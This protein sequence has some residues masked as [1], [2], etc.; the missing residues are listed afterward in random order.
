MLLN[1]RQFKKILAAGDTDKVS[2]SKSS[3]ADKEVKDK[4]TETPASNKTLVQEDASPVSAPAAPS[5][6][7]SVSDRFHHKSNYPGD[8]EDNTPLLD[9][10]FTTLPFINS[11]QLFAAFNDSISS[12][13]HTIHPWQLDMSNELCQPSKQP[14]S[15]HPLKY[16]LVAANGS[17]KDSFIIAPFAVW[18]ILTKI[19]SRV[20]I[21]SSSGTQLTSQ[22]ETYIKALAERINER[23]GIEIFR[24]RQRYIKCRKTGSEIRMFA[25]D[26]AG[27][28]EG[29]HP[30]DPGAEMCIIINEGKSIAPEIYQ[31][32]RRC[33][34]Y[35]Y[36]IEVSSPGEPNGD[37]YESYKLYKHN[38]RIT[39]FDCPNISAD[40]IL[41]DKIRYG[42]HSAYYRSKHLALF[43]SIGGNVI[44]PLELID[45]LKANP[46]KLE[47]SNGAKWKKRFGIDMSKGRDEIVCTCTLG[48]RLIEEYAFREEDTTVTAELIHGFLK[49]HLADLMDYEYIFGDDGGIG[50][51]IIDMLKRKGWNIKRIHNQSPA[52]NKRH[53]GNRGAEAWDRVKRLFEEGIFDPSNFSEELINQLTQRKIRDTIV[54]SKVFLQSKADAKAHGQKSP[55]RADAFILSLTGLTLE[56][57]LEHVRSTGE[58]PANAGLQPM[59]QSAM[60]KWYADNITYGNFKEEQRPGDDGKNIH[61]SLQVALNRQRN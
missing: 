2:S 5:L 61:G 40:E 16:C 31:A 14:T 45:R 59:D 13:T 10:E 4:Q 47:F 3:I 46:P 9:N 12:G 25:T 8:I 21:T 55:D 19:R 27:K 20:I 26:E 58:L 39:S 54:G 11:L 24:V 37:F 44:I 38:R 60:E 56:D 33:S 49:K 36:W 28:A 53:F 52:V 30:L 23:M 42:E 41:E 22:T 50:G 34:G 43:T 1:D 6:L 18:F 32:L 57:F 29:Y 7:D 15:Q 51:A 17:G 48:N 35:N